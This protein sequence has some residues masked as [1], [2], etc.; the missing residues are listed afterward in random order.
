[1][2][3]RPVIPE[4]TRQPYTD[5][6]AV[7]EDWLTFPKFGGG[8]SPVVKRATFL[9]GDAV[10]VLPYDPRQGTV[11]FVRQ[12]RHGA[13]ARGD[14]NPWTL[15]PAA[16][17]IDPG[18]SPE[19]A[20]RRELQEEVGLTVGDLHLAARYY[21]TPGAVSEYLF[22]YVASADLA[23]K[24]GTIGGVDGEAED[25]MSH[26]IPLDEALGMIET[27]AINTG[28]LILSLNWLALN[29]ERFG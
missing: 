24:D 26:V 21:P 22:S 6:F 8:E 7:R 17:R 29:R 3:G 14:R 2:A 5:Y 1:M 27:G 23:G 12:F 16:G 20:A 28:P 25:I 19:A 9:G 4:T 18:E 10:T 15:E 13:F 11:L